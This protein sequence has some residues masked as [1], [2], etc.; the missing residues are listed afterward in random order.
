MNI[1]ITHTNPSDCAKTLDD[2]RLNKMILET[3][4]LL[5]TAAN[6]Y[7]VKT[8]YKPTHRN[9]PCTNWTKES[10][11]NYYW[12][13]CYWQ[14]LITEYYIRFNKFHKCDELAKELYEAKDLLPKGKLTKWANCTTFKHLEDTY[15]AYKQYLCFKWDNDKRPAKWTN[16]E[17]PIFYIEHNKLKKDD[18]SNINK[19][20]EDTN[21][22]LNYFV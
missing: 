8:T 6:H 4:Q 2:K 21:E 5:S 18:N 19:N 20:N 11:S 12:L 17:T 14:C 1:F 9:H 3:A 13:Y 22:N 16:R 15:E 7:G 10:Q